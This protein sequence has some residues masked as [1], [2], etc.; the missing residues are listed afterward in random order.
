MKALR[1]RLASRIWERVAVPQG[2]IRTSVQ[3]SKK[4]TVPRGIDIAVE[5]GGT[6][7]LNASPAPNAPQVARGSPD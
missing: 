2:H 6:S 5:G 3:M 4:L 7:T 1:I